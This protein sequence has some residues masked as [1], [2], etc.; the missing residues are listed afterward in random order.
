[1]DTSGTQALGTTTFLRAH[2]LR[3][4]LEASAIARLVETLDGL[5]AEADSRASGDAL[6]E[7]CAL[8]WRRR[9][10]ALLGE[11]AALLPQP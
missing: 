1:M 4:L 7:H 10:D 2:E 9:R 11:H 6:A 8:S 3:A 5:I